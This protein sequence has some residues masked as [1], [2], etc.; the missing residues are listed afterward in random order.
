MTTSLCISL[1]WRSACCVRG[2]PAP[3]SPV[4]RRGRCLL[5]ISV[6]HWRVSLTTDG[7][8]TP[9]TQGQTFL[10]ISRERSIGFSPAATSHRLVPSVWRSVMKSRWDWQGSLAQEPRVAQY[11]P[12]L[13][14]SENQSC[15]SPLVTWNPDK[16]PERRTVTDP[17]WS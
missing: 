11:Q 1:T 10:L 15:S 17:H 9:A 13:G 8:R 12:A 6:A 14:R 5:S 7:P 16:T 2:K 4:S 3:P